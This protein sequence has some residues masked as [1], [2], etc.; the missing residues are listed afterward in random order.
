MLCGA[1][2]GA[3]GGAA[4][5]M[6]TFDMLDNEFEVLETKVETVRVALQQAADDSV[7]VRKADIMAVW[8][9]LANASRAF[10]RQ[11][12]AVSSPRQPNRPRTRHH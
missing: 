12:V 9:A 1:L 4:A 7:A 5:D 6:D 8:E 10:G 3:A 11:S 2:L